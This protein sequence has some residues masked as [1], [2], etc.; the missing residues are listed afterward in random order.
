MITSLGAQVMLCTALGGEI[1]ERAA[2][3]ARAEGSRCGRSTRGPASGWYVHDRRDGERDEVADHSGAPLDR[4][5]LDELY[6]LALAE[7]LRAGVR[8]QRGRGPGVVAPD[9][10]PAAGRRPDRQRRAG[11]RRPVRRAPHRR[12]RGRRHVPQGEPRGAAS[13]P[14]GPTTSSSRRWPAP[15][16]SCTRRAPRRCWSAAPTSRRLALLD[17]RLFEV[18][19]PPLQVADHRGAGDS[20]T[21]GVAAVLARGGDLHRG[22]PHRR[23]RRRRQRH[24]A[25]ARHRPGRGDPCADRAGRA[26]PR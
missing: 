24:P 6:N 14:A 12:A 8:A 7:G 5:E 13:P 2:V 1:G 26:R 11:D 21:A 9:V 3:A 23:G 19:V 17:G 20:M 10:V 25:R 22:G 15:R 16:A 18:E 4:H